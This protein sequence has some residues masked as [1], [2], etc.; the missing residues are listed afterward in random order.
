MLLMIVMTLM[1]QW[2]EAARRTQVRHWFVRRLQPL[3]PDQERRWQ[4][5][6]ADGRNRAEYREW[7]RLHEA[8][9]KMPPPQLQK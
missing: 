5:W 3:S 6:L 8:L 9:R 1:L 7:V 2:Q 4:R